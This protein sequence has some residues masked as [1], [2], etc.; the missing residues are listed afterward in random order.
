MPV[1]YSDLVRY[2]T[3]EGP[4]EAYPY[5]ESMHQM[6]SLTMVIAIVIGL[7]FIAIGRKGRSLWMLVWGAGLLILAVAYL[8]ADFSGF[9]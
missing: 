9:I 6:L 1:V 7:I 2:R 3:D 8:I 4:N 5:S